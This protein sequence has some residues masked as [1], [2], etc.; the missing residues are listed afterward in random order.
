MVHVAGLVGRQAELEIFD[1]ACQELEQGR[2][3]ALEVVGE[4]GI[5]KTRILGELE[6]RAE[7]LGQ[8]VLSG[9]A[10]ELERDLP[11]GVFVDALDD[12]VHSLD[13]RRLVSLDDDVRKELAAI[14]PSL[15]LLAPRGKDA[16][17]ERYRSYRAVRELLELLAARKPLV[18]VLDDL[19]WADPASVELVGALLRRPPEAPVLMAL[20]FRPRQLSERLFAALSRAQR[21]GI[22]ARAELTPLT[23][24]EARE[25]LGDERAGLAERL[26]TESGGNPFYLEQLARST[27]RLPTAPGEVAEISLLGVDVPPLVVAALSEELALLPETARLVLEGAAVAGD[28]FEPELAAAAAATS[29]ESAIESLDVLLGL[30]LIRTTDVPRRYRF[31]HPLLRR[32]VYDSAPG[33]WRLGAHERSAQALAARGASAL[34][35]AHHVERSARQ[36]DAMAVAVLREAGEAA[37]HLAPGS[38]ARWFTAALR[39]VSDDA[40][41]EERVEL[42]LALARVLAAS[43]SFAE[44]RSALITS[45]GARTREVHRPAPAVD[46]HLCGS[47]ASAWPPRAG[48][49]SARERS[50]RS[51]RP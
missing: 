47:R 33:G 2:S 26:H 29:E 46:D 5:G 7:S 1:Q 28:P 18:L 27:H 21:A 30:D 13:E 11:L 40:P 8:L 31:R 10:S 3:A 44:S 39:L 12:Y 51:R 32:A 34:S 35:R 20:A 15:S 9:S 24:A 42:L 45:I 25:L 48:A 19:H 16:H 37:A 23:L 17:N 50:R 22:L 4:P 49:S 36:G 6:R 41:A 43:G 14:F 38:A